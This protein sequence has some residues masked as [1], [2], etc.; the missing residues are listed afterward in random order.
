MADLK[1]IGSEKLQGQE[2]LNRILE[3]ARYKENIPQTVNETA[4]VEFGKTLSDG[5]QYE[6]VKEKGGYVLMKRINESLDYM[7]L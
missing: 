2:K 6:I 5:N 7:N 3:I 4:K 1:P